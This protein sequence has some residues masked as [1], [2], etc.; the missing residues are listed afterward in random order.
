MTQV[1]MA[2]ARVAEQEAIRQCDVDT[3]E[4]PYSQFSIH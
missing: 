1:K 2:H 3:L 4:I